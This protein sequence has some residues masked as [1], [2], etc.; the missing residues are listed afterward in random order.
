MS[1]EFCCSSYIHRSQTSP[2]SESRAESRAATGLPSRN[3]TDRPEWR[4]L[5]AIHELVTRG[6]ERSHTRRR[7]IVVLNSSRRSERP[8]P[9]RRFCATSRV[10]AGRWCRVSHSG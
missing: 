5:Q 8:T 9:T 4:C 2:E 7:P 3:G 6:C 1:E 10:P